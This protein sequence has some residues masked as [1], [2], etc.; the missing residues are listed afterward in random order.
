M[1][2]SA[3]F[4][5][6]AVVIS[7]G[8]T[9]SVAAQDATRQETVAKRGADMMPF[10]LNAT[11]HVFTKTRDGGI[12]GVLAKNPDDVGQISLIRDHLQEIR[13]QFA[14][15]DFSGPAHIHGAG[16]PGLAELKEA[17]SQVSVQYRATSAGAELVYSTENPRLVSAIH[18]WFD[19]QLS[20]HGHDA[21]AGHDHAMMHH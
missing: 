19:A 4:L 10:D 3:V 16:M 18:R 17:P 13:A 12:Q 6:A 21:M 7:S 11:T 5:F 9:V 1:K 2:K 8:A 14:K 20:D 15:G